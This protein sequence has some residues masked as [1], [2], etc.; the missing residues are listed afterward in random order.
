MQEKMDIYDGNTAGVN[1]TEGKTTKSAQRVAV[2]GATFVAKTYGFMTGGLAVSFIV[3]LITSL[4]FPTAMFKA[5]FYFTVLIGELAVA[6][7]FSFGFR[8]LSPFATGA[9]FF[10]YS[11]FTGFSLSVFMMFY[12]FKTFYLAFGVTGTMFLALTVIGFVTKKDVSR[13]GATI[14]AMLIGLLISSVIAFIIGGELEM[15]VCGLGVLI[16]GAVTVYDTK[17]IRHFASLAIA[18]DM[19]NKYVIYSAMQLYLDYINILL[20]LIRLLGAINRRNS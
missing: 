1:F 5:E 18:E 8:R 11:V 3:A 20:Y 12:G 7:I 9:L 2:D 13:M 17:K 16:F 10:L 4:F 19:Q 15:I 14:S 6:L